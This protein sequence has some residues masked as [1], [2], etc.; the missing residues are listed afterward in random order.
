[1]PAT[2]SLQKMFIINFAH[3]YFFPDDEV[4]KQLLR[5]TPQGLIK[6]QMYSKKDEQR[7]TD[8]RLNRV[9]NKNA[10]PL[11]PWAH[12]V[13]EGMWSCVVDIRSCYFLFQYWIDQ[14]C[15]F[16]YYGY[17]APWTGKMNQILCRDC[18]P[19]SPNGQ[20]GAIYRPS[21][22]IQERWLHI[23]LVLFAYKLAKRKT[24][25]LSWPHTGSIIHIFWILP[26]DPRIQ[27]FM[28]ILIITNSIVLGVQAGESLILEPIW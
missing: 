9:K 16:L 18:P 25:P 15:N 26:T 1:M 19:P 11:G 4:M 5:E 2:Y 10:I 6:F 22:F 24:W 23:S 8:R 12:T 17:I 28:M 13:I 21:L 27:N 7:F 14:I 20:D 3:N